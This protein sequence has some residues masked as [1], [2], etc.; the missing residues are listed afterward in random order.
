MSTTTTSPASTNTSTSAAP[1]IPGS[2]AQVIQ[3]DGKIL[4]ALDGTNAVELVAQ[5][6]AAR[7]AERIA[8]K[9]A[10]EARGQLLAL[11]G[12]ANAGTVEG[13]VI[14]YLTQAEREG[15][16]IEALKGFDY[17]WQQVRDVKVITT[18]RV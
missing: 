15:V 2:V 4:A 11:L 14:V 8:L 10:S 13:E 6:K 5:L 12:A 18:V 9:Q 17:V 1:V 3:D 7:A 16:D